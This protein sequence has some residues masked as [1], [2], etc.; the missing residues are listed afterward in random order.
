M[1]NAIVLGMHRSG[2][3]MIAHQLHSFGLYVGAEAEM[4]V[5]QADN[6]RGFWERRDVVELNDQILTDASS[7]WYM[8]P[9]R[10]SL[11]SKSYQKQVGEIL[12]TM[13]SRGWLLKDPRMLLTWPVWEPQIAGACKVFVYRDPVAVASSLSA[14]HG[15]P[16]TLGL[17]LWEYYNR[18]ALEIVSKS[19][20]IVVNYER[21]AR[22]PYAQSRLLLEQLAMHGADGLSIPE[23]TVFDNALYQRGQETRNLCTA[24][25]LLTQNQ[26]ELMDTL[27]GLSSSD[28]R[29]HSSCVPD[30]RLLARVRDVGG[31]LRELATVQELRLQRNE[32]LEQVH[33]GNVR[34]QSSDAQVKDL[35]ALRDG[36]LAAIDVERAEAARLLDT[37]STIYSRL[38]TYELSLVGK[39]QRG[40]RRAYATLR[41]RRTSPGGYDDV[42]TAAREHFSLHGMQVPQKPPGKLCQ[43]KAVVRYVWHNPVSSFRSISIPRL[44]RAVGIMFSSTPTD[45]SV[46][47]KSRFPDTER[48]Q[49]FLHAL[50]ARDAQPL[51][52]TFPDF[53]SPTVS[54]IV[55]V[56]NNYSTTENCLSSILAHTDGVSY[57]VLVA[58][59]ASSDAT[60]SIASRMQNIRVVRQDQNLGFLHN[61]KRA[62]EEATGQ[63]LLFL[64]NDTAVC[65]GW[66]EPLVNQ[67]KCNP[68]VGIAGPKLL[69][70]DGTLQEAGGIVWNDG[71]AWNYGRC[72]DPLKPEYEYVKEVDYISGACLMIRATLWHQLGGFDERFSPAYYEDTDLCFAVRE[73][74]FK[75]VYEPRSSVFHFE[76]VS[77]GTDIAKG[78]KRY[79]A[80]NRRKFRDKWASVLD[81]ENFANGERVFLAR[82]RSGEKNCILVIDHYVPHYDKDAG[83]RSSLMYIR[84]MVELGFK[85]VFLGANFFPHQPY[86]RLLQT[87]GVEVLYGEHSARHIDRWLQSNAPYIHRIFLHRP[88]VAEQFLPHIEQMNPR[89]QIV[90]FG[91]DLHY[92]RAEREQVLLADNAQKGDASSWKSREFA[93]FGRVDTVYYPSLYEVQALRSESPGLNVKA[94]PLYIFDPI[95]VPVYRPARKHDILFVAGFNHP[96]NVDGLVWFVDEVMPQLIELCPEVHLHIVGSNPTQGV[97]AMQSA[98]N[99]VHGYI[100]DAELQALYRV[101][102]CSIV[103]LRYGA[104]VKGKVL[105]AINCGV[106]LVTTTVGA[107]GISKAADVM[108]IADNEYS[109]AHAIADVLAGKGVDEKL[110]RY[111]SWL[112]ENFGREKAEAIILEDFG[113]VTRH[114]AVCDAA[115]GSV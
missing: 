51:E 103:P 66:L 33:T 87:M 97:L 69:F 77:N 28:C 102:G 19:D 29:K 39:L 106:P 112:A 63:Y 99:T 96:P 7:S 80:E 86:T 16:L 8:P 38:L 49:A 93:V 24:S 64:N 75:V 59:D 81:R 44:S 79:Q 101:V 91:H 13:P 72:D 52:L 89:P 27:A 68:Y 58:D 83:S 11:S 107:E 50:P 17:E 61:C 113:P 67:L 18:C 6:P 32:L 14:R 36:L 22:D 57:E 114:S 53:E 78:V 115:G 40:F 62:A 85:V 90:F 100:S 98:R 34:L 88:H 111:S 54:I 95:S 76:G 42:L 56:H 45:F 35:Q 105:E 43:L 20:V 4:L 65:K 71:S 5:A 55:P 10:S 31:A 104:G 110:E 41:R 108:F 48:P 2:T 3:S 109:F 47:V 21:F 12:S 1:F 15:F 84:M 74:G 30:E 73:A 70:P 92:L 60:T 82:D 37:I 9:I 25:S 46:W 94:L 26:R 23:K